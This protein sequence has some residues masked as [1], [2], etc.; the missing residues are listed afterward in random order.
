MPKELKDK[1]FID[2]ELF[3]FVSK[4][5]LKSYLEHPIECYDQNGNLDEEIYLEKTTT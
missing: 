5:Q 4:A 1:K 3:R 2:T